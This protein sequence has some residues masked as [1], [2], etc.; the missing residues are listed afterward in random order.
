MHDRISIL[1]YCFVG[2]IGILYS[3]KKSDIIKTNIFYMEELIREQRELSIQV[4][5]HLWFLLYHL[6]ITG[7]QM[8]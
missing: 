4:Q 2:N 5:R 7:K 8:N 1:V 6:V 3:A